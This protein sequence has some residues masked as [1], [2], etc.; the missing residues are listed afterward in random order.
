M[1]PQLLTEVDFERLR[2][3]LWVERKYDGH[4]LLIH[5]DESGRGSAWSREGRPVRAAQW[6]ADEAARVAPAGWY[7]GEL[8][9]ETWSATQSAVM[10]RDGSKLT[11]WAFDA[12]TPEE[13]TDGGSQVPLEARR[14]RLQALRDVP[15]VRLVESALCESEDRLGELFLAAMAAGHEGLVTKACGSG[16][17]CG[18][19]VPTWVKVKPC[20]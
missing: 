3:P 12:L 20:S 15:G 13:V 5:V 19:R 16:Y 6:I 7:D 9:G 18:T 14:A 1:K 10:R 11:W 4:R 2:Y 17:A 8:A